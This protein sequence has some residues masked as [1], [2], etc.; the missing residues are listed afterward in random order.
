MQL[1]KLHRDLVQRKL[2]TEEDFWATRQV[3]P[4]TVCRVADTQTH[5][6]THRHLCTYTRI[7]TDIHR[8]TLVPG[9]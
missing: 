3:R 1:V 2:I 9:R 6:H 8:R 5:T 4:S 7:Q